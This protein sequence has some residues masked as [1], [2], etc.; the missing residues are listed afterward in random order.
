MPVLEVKDTIYQ[1]DSGEV[2]SNLLKRSTLFAGQAPEA[3]RLQKYTKINQEASKEELENT[4]GT[5]AV[6]YTHLNMYSIGIRGGI[7][8]KQLRKQLSG[9][10]HICKKE[11]LQNAWTNR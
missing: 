1:S 10:K 3:F 7:S 5:S 2:I 11:M 6:S 8:R 9:Q 4:C